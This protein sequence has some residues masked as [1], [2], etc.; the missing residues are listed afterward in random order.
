MSLGDCFPDSFKTS[1]AEQKEIKVSDVL[2]LH[3][4]FTTPPKKKYLVVCCCE[5]LLVLTINSEIHPFIQSN[6]QLLECQ[7]DILKEDHAFLKW[8]SYVSCIEA[9][10]AFDLKD[11]KSR[12]MHDYTNIFVGEVVPYCMR[13]VYQAVN[14]SK[15]MTRKHKRLILNSLSEFQ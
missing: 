9:H 12:I 8:D 2:L 15:T 4:E 14:R 13:D 10:Q 3:C 5:P 1:F 7:V 11:I 6:A